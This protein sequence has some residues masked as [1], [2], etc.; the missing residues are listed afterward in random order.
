MISVNKLL[1]LENSNKYQRI[2]LLVKKIRIISGRINCDHT[3]EK[4]QIYRRKKSGKDVKRKKEKT[5]TITKP[6]I[7]ANFDESIELCKK[8]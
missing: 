2:E 1:K 4:Y 6:G 7:L 8:N 5:N 3:W